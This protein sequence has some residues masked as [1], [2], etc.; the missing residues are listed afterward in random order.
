MIFTIATSSMMIK[1]PYGIWTGLTDPMTFSAATP[2][3]FAVLMTTEPFYL[4]L[5]LWEKVYRLQ[6]LLLL[7]Q[8]TSITW[9]IPM[10]GVWTSKSSYQTLTSS[11][12]KYILGLNGSKNKIIYGRSNI[13]KS[14]LPVLLSS[15]LRKVVPFTNFVLQLH[16]E[17]SKNMN[18]ERLGKLLLLNPYST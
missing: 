15:R 9:S 6:L 13:F 10:T 18:M 8:V 5:T 17:S 2:I 14:Y 11:S 16:Y 12:S 1:T 3:L 7:L 4:L